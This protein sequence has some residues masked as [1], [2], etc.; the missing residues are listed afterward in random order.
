[1]GTSAFGAGCQEG[2]GDRPVAGVSAERQLGRT[3]VPKSDWRMIVSE[4]TRLELDWEWLLLQEMVLS[5]I[6][7]ERLWEP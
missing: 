1:M 7:S 4:E 6:E 5:R 2:S 3:W